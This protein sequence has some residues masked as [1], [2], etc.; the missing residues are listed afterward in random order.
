MFL[1]ASERNLKLCLRILQWFFELSGFTI[2]VKK[3]KVIRIGNIRESDRRYCKENNLDWV[4]KFETLGISYDIL[5]MHNITEININEKIPL[6]LHLIQSWSK[7]NITPL[8]RITVLKSLILS[9]IT[10]ILISLPAPNEEIFKTI[11]KMCIDFIWKGGRHEVSK[12]TLYRYIK[13]GGLNMMNI[14]DFEY[15]LKLTWI[16]R[17]ITGNPVWTEFAEKYCINHLYQT[18][19]NYHH[20]LLS[21]VK[22]KFWHSVIKA[23]SVWFKKLK[24]ITNFSADNVKIWGNPEIKLQFNIKIY[25]GNIR[26]ISDLY[27]CDWIRLS[28]QDIEIKVGTKITFIEYH[29]LYKSIPGY[30]KDEFRNKSKS[31]NMSCPIEIHYLTKDKKGTR[32][33]REIFTKNEDGVPIGQVKWNRELSLPNIN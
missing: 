29:A 20:N 4:S 6:M 26:Y 23:Y 11:E 1:K 17:L 28:Q 19:E 16:R 24:H 13:S 21:T 30:I 25:N 3:T 33:L 22:N 14:R 15:S 31:D 10:H 2:N 9:K 5:N 7:R 27:N 12:S 18:D 8:G 32:Y